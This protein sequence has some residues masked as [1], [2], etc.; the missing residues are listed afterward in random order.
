VVIT[1]RRNLAVDGRKGM[2]LV[3]LVPKIWNLKTGQK[4]AEKV[5]R[6]T[7]RAHNWYTAKLCEHVSATTDGQ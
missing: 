6:Q 7:T 1:L 2:K 5:I 3:L 4:N